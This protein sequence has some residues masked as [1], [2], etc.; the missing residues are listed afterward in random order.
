MH[1]VGFT[2]EIYYDARPYEHQISIFNGLPWVWQKKPGD[3]MK[4]TIERLAY[5][6]NAPIIAQCTRNPA[7]NCHTVPKIGLCGKHSSASALAK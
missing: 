3:T 4:G 6:R 7:N 1:L 5:L 2:T